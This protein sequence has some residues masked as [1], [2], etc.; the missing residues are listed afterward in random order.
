MIPSVQG[1]VKVSVT[2]YVATTFPELFCLSLGSVF[3]L[4]GRVKVFQHFQR[5]N[6]RGVS[7]AQFSFEV[8]DV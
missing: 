4:V 5:R 2:G 6:C 3:A 7:Y 8:G 1:K